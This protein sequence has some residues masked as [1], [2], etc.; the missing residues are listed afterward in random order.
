MSFWNPIYY[1]VKLLFCTSSII[2]I[3]CVHY[4]SIYEIEYYVGR[5][6]NDMQLHVVVNIYTL[7]LIIFNFI[8]KFKKIIKKNYILHAIYLTNFA[9]QF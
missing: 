4:V 8:L 5:K 6:I 9:G 2:Y 3:L 7:T 1:L